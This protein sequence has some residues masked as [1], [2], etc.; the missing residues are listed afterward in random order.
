MQL[1]QKFLLLY[2]LCAT[3]SS[4]IWQCVWREMWIQDAD[5]NR[6]HL[7]QNTKVQFKSLT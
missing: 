6:G 4:Q 1:C 3:K 5:F 2:N 7:K